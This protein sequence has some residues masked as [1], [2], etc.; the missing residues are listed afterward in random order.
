LGRYK[1]PVDQRDASHSRVGQEHADLGVLDPA[2]RAG[3]LARHPGRVRALLD[4]PGLVPHQHRGGVA[5][6]FDG[7]LAQ[8]ITHAVSVPAGAVEQPLHPIRGQLPGLFSQ[9]PAV[10]ALQRAEQPLQVPKG[11]AARLDASEPR[12]D[13]LVQL[14]QPVRPHP[15]LL[16]GLLDLAARPRRAPY[17]L[18]HVTRLPDRKAGNLPQTN[19]DRRTTC[20]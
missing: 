16:L 13:P 6:V 12:P 11:S 7:V 3:V 1:V 18:R 15:R 5:Q 14:D 10:L 20:P 9:P 2:G 17:C 4:E 19:C 8:V